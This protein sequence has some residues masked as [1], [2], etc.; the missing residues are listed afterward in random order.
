[1]RYL[2]HSTEHEVVAVCTQPD[3]P[4]G[5]GL[6]L[7]SSPVKQVA[8]AA[9]IP[10]F[11]P[12]ST[13]DPAFL[14]DLQNLEADLSVVV[15]YSLLPQAAIAATRLGAVNLHGSLLPNYRGAA[16]VQWAIANGE[17]ESGLTVFALDSKMDHGP[18]LEQRKIPIEASDTAESLLA[19]MV[20]PGCAAIASALAKIE[21]GSYSPLPQDHSQ[22]SPAPKLKKEDAQID[23]NWSAHKIDCRLRGFTPWPG[24]FTTHNGKKI[25]IRK[26]N[27]TNKLITNRLITNKLSPGECVLQNGE[28]FAGT[29]EGVL[30]IEEVQAEGKKRMA[31][32][33]FAR[34]V[35][36]GA[37]WFGT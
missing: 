9:G 17:S 5:R 20:E 2:L 29:G 18:V 33:D 3:R 25:F 28:L 37:L 23:W 11:Q 1:L 26:T 8:V 36:G 10:V 19:K 24:A 21:D 15:A 22:A 32:A 16:P 30:H 7:Q 6:A 4:A 31:A 14:R 35:H 27:L 12:E 13:K 34:G